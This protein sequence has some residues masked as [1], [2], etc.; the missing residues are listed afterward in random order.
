LEA[1]SHDF[2]AG[3]GLMSYG[4][5]IL[6]RFHGGGVYTG[7][8]LHGVKP[9]DMPVQQTAKFEFTI[10]LQTARALGIEIP[11]G[12]FAAKHDRGFRA[13]CVPKLE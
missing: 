4:A 1:A 13:A 9:A 12:F 2:V 5:D 10:N 3:G 11:S 6:E 7:K 8:V